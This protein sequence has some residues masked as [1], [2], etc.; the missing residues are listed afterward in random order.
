MGE[1]MG[2]P[3][4]EFIRELITQLVGKLSASDPP[5]TPIPPISVRARRVVSCRL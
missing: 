3:M 1:L 4:G 5:I 2:E